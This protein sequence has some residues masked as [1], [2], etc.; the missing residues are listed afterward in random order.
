MNKIQADIDKSD[1]DNYP[2]FLNI[3]IDGDWL[4]ELVDSLYPD[5]SVKGAIPTLS[6]GMDRDSE[7]KVV[8]DRFLPHVGSIT[9]CPVLM[10][11]DDC[12]FYCICIVA[13]IENNGSA[14][15][16]S[17]LGSDGSDVRDA[18]NVGTDVKWFP[19]FQKLEFNLQDYTKVL[20]DFKRQFDLKKA[21]YKVQSKKFAE[22]QK[23]K[24]K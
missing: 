17:K 24:N 11:P 20:E 16:W 12:D 18:N 1:Y 14:I 4:D 21:D 15:V 13:E 7:E 3:R 5:K 23:L 6:F 8:W 9:Y 22:E 2:D 10:C 19:N